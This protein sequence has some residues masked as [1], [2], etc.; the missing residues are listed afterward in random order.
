[1]IHGVGDNDVGVVQREL[2]AVLE[3]DMAILDPDATRVIDVEGAGC[4]D[5]HMN[6]ADVG[7]E[8]FGASPDGA[9]SDGGG[10]G[11]VAEGDVAIS[12]RAGG[13]GFARITRGDVRRQVVQIAKEKYGV[14]IDDD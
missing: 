7:H 10:G 1:M 3:P 5:V 6:K 14:E 4:G 13:H 12:R 11:D 8:H 2:V 9:A